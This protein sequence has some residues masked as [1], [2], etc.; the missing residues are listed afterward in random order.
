MNQVAITLDGYPS[1]RETCTDAVFVMRSD[2]RMLSQT[3][4]LWRE[5]Q[6]ATSLVEYAPSKDAQEGQRKMVS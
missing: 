4:R 3:T 1:H 5:A 2:V 6:T